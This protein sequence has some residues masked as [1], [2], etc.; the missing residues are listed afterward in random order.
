MMI[1]LHFDLVVPTL[2]FLHH[3]RVAPNLLMNSIF[4]TRL[5]IEEVEEV[6]LLFQEIM[7]IQQS[8]SFFV[9][10]VLTC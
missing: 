9:T 4:V 3:E 10:I 8:L 6:N 2:L 7:M 1:H 5:L